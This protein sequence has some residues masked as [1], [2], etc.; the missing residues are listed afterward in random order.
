MHELF[1]D[2]ETIPDQRPGSIDRYLEM[3]KPPGRYSKPES[4]DR[5]MKDNAEAAAVE[6][7]KGSALHGIA[8]EIVSIA[9]AFDDEDVDCGIRSH[10]DPESLLL[11]KFFDAI[12]EHAMLGEGRYPTIRWIG[13]NVLGFDLRFLFQRCVILGVE[14]PV[15]L[16]VDARQGSD[17]VYDTMLAWGGWKGFVKQDALVE[18]LG[19]EFEDEEGVDGSQ[20]WDLVQSGQLDVVRK[21]N[22]LDVEKCRKIYRAM[23]WG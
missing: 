17:K 6:N 23:T 20:V 22:M 10:T 2:L 4:I 5:W 15:K 19:L 1:I 11:H 12:H 18:A 21:Y 9:W 8:G 14:P 7:W 13:H 16:P 3:V